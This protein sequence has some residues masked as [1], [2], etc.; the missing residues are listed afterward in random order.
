MVGGRSCRLSGCIALLAVREAECTI[1]QCL[2]TVAIDWNPMSSICT[3]WSC[4]VQVRPGD[5]P[6]R[7]LRASFA[8]TIWMPFREKASRPTCDGYRPR[9]HSTRFRKAHP[10]YRLREVPQH[11][12][13]L[14]RRRCRIER[15]KL[16][17]RRQ[18]PNR[19]RNI[20]RHD[21]WPGRRALASDG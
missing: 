3:A 15:Q 8:C 6:P 17:R 21:S 7:V 20:C 4:P 9:L 14:D 19:I 12:L 11:G 1:F 16:H 18:R 10:G 5:A 2:P 13:C